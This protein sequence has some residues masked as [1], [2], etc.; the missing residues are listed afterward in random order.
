MNSTFHANLKIRTERLHVLEDC[1]SRP[2]HDDSRSPMPGRKSPGA[3]SAAILIVL[4]KWL[5][6]W[7]EH[8]L[9]KPGE[10]VFKNNS[11]QYSD[12]IW[13][14]ICGTWW[15]SKFAMRITLLWGSFSCAKEGDQF[16]LIFDTRGLNQDF[17]L[18]PSTDLPAADAFTRM[19]FAEDQPF[20]FDSGDL[21]NGVYTLEVFWISHTVSLCP[22]PGQLELTLLADL[23]FRLVPK[24]SLS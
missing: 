5:A 20:V 14:L 24:Q 10:A 16:R 11:A 4:W 21:A 13:E 2:G 18:P 15:P 9:K 23:V 17:N 1:V 6:A 7:H 12:F 19:S 8:V 22:R 3:R